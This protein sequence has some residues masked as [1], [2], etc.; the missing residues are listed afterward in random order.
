M[1]I[2]TI[3]YFDTQAYRKSEYFK[4]IT[5]MYIHFNTNIFYEYIFVNTAIY[6]FF[7][8]YLLQHFKLTL[9]LCI[10]LF[11]FFF[12]LMIMEIPL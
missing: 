4:I 5:Y 11:Y 1:T 3:F 8:E 10:Y 2:G 7:K 12:L 6:I 9:D